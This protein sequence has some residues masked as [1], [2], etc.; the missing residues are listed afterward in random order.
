MQF[1]PGFD[2]PQDAYRPLKL[3][4]PEMVLLWQ[5]CPYS[6][7][8]VRG[9]LKQWHCQAVCLKRIPES[10]LLFRELRSCLNRLQNYLAEVYPV[11]PQCRLSASGKEQG[12]APCLSRIRERYN[13][14]PFLC[15]DTVL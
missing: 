13:Q 2:W 6:A 1:S 4:F 14:F 11:V 9:Y 3:L 10:E 8:P 15:P 12:H 7:R 5:R